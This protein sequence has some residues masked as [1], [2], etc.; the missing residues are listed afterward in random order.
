MVALRAIAGVRPRHRVR[1]NTTCE[2]Q[3]KAA[4]QAAC[5]TQKPVASQSESEAH[6]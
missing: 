1:A 2:T 6:E 4:S 5:E 3:G